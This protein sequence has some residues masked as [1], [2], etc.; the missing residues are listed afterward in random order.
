MIVELEEL[1]G[2]T[3]DSKAVQ[4]LA[5]AIDSYDFDAALKELDSLE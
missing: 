5:K 2:D 1:D 4:R 3:L